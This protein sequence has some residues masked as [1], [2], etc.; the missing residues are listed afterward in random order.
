MPTI[1]LRLPKTT[2]E[3]RGITSYTT[4]PEDCGGGLRECWGNA[5][6]IIRTCYGDFVPHYSRPDVRTKDVKSISFHPNG[7]VHSIYLENQSPVQTSIGVF[8][9]ELITFHENGSLDSVFPLNGQIG[10]GWSE[11]DEKELAQD[12]TIELPQGKITVKINGIR[13]FPDGRLRNIIFWSG[14]TVLLTTPAGE[15]PVRRGVCFYEDG[16]MKSFEPAIPINLKTPIGNVL[17]YNI[18]ATSVESDFNSVV[19]DRNGQ[20]FSVTTSGDII[21]NHARFGRKRI[22]S[23][24]RLGLSD[25]IT[26]RMPLTITFNNNDTVTINNGNE[27]LTTILSESKFLILPDIEVTVGLGCG[28][29]CSGCNNCNISNNSN[30]IEFLTIPFAATQI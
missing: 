17:S 18:N 13:F 4:Y 30:M 12:Y 16:Q 19:F 25:D 2:F 9:A 11:E 8:P 14:E 5:E 3:L 10:F 20:L 7:N 29:R 28:A 24:T 15:F 1:D 26:V 6:N 23:Q 22:S 27:S 21:V